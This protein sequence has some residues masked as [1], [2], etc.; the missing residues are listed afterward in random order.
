VAV[1]AEPPPIRPRDAVGAAVV[2]PG[3]RAELWA[4]ASTSARGARYVLDGAGLREVGPV[5]GF[6]VF[7]ARSLELVP[8]RNT[9][10]GGAG[11]ALHGVRC[12]DDLVDPQGRALRVEAVLTSDGMLGV[13][14]S[15]ERA[16]PR[17]IDVTG[18]GTAFEVADVDND[19]RPEL[20]HAGAGAPG[21]A[22]ALAVHSLPASGVVLDKPV[23]R[24]GFSGGVAGVVAADVDGDGDVDVLAAV[25]LPGAQKVDLWLLD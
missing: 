2:V 21:D 23:Y 12:R 10:A 19:G 18:V 11:A 3:A 8:G 17:R 25:R 15:S 1:P 7:A 16:A 9:F 14:V 4:R 13:V 22:D 6:P 5:T 20:I 24:R